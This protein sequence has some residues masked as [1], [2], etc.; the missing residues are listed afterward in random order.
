MHQLPVNPLRL[1]RR[2]SYPPDARGFAKWKA[3]CTTLINAY[4][5]LGNQSS[6]VLGASCRHCT[7]R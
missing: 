7:H 1:W 6:L 5:F 4:W 2:L 3:S